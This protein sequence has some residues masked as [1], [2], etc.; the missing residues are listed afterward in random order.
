MD[1]VPVVRFP[2]KK[3]RKYNEFRIVNK[4]L[5]SLPFL[6][7]VLEP[8]WIKAQGPFCPSLIQY[9]TEH[10]DKFDVFVFVTY[11]YYTTA[12]GLPRVAEKAIFVP[13]A[14]DEYCIYFHLY[15]RLFQK[16]KGIIYL[17]EEE[18]DFVQK[19]FGNGKIPYQIAGAGIDVPDNVDTAGFRE[20]F[21]ILSDYVLYVGRVD[22]GKNC[23]DLFEYFNKFNEARQ[24]QLELV[25]VG[26]IMMKK[27]ESEH[28]HLLG[29]VSEEEKY[30]AIAG[31]KVLIMP[32]A[33]ESLSLVVLESMAMGI[34]VIVNGACAVLEGHC[35]KSGAGISYKDYFQFEEGLQRVLWDLELYRG[36]QAAGKKY[37]R[38][39]YSWEH[40]IEKFH[41]IIEA[42]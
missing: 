24:N 21:H 30:A 34:P 26:K 39:Y 19:L 28:I 8:M 29:Y 40:T 13:T 1:G 41:Q 5:L 31:A 9:I 22:I 20:K 23:D 16:V 4:M 35:R 15:R 11:L 27:P 25:V 6:W 38:E 33:H 2:V 42:V 32:S 36:M 17:T 14:H 10:Q 12:I 7:R 18:C 37:V 3:Q